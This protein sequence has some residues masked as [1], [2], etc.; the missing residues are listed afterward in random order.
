MLKGRGAKLGCASKRG[1][2]EPKKEGG[3]GQKVGGETRKVGVEHKS[4]G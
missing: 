1:E 4:W 2:L 3:G